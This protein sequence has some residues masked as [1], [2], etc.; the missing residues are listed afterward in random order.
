MADIDDPAEAAIRLEAALE[1]IAALAARPHVPSGNTA[2]AARVA[3]R[4][5]SLITQLRAALGAATD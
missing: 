2:E 5:D 4:L 3:A 1:R